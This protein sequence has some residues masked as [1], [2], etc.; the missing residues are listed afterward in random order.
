M[1]RISF[2]TLGCNKNLVDSEVALGNLLVHGYNCIVPP[3]EAEWVF[4]N[5]C[6]FIRPSC[7]E[8]EAWIEKLIALKRKDPRKKIVVLGCYVERFREKAFSRYQEVDYWVGVHDVL[9]LPEI[10]SSKRKGVFM[11]S[12]PSIYTHQSP[13]LL[14][15]PPHYAYVKIAEGCPH[16]CSFC[17]IP[18]IRGP[19]R[20]RSIDSVVAEVR[21]LQERGV[22]EII[23]VAQDLTSYGLDLYRKRSLPDLLRAL[24]L[25]LQEGIWVRLLYLSPEGINDEL[26]EVV[27]S[28]PQIVK[29]LDI[30]LQHVEPFILQRMHRFSHFEEIRKRLEKLRERIPGVAIR[31][32]FIVGFPGEEEKHFQ[33]LLHFVEEFQFER[34]GAFKYSDEEG[35]ASFLLKPKVPEEV[36]EKRYSY[37]MEVQK[38]VMERF[39]QSLQGK[40]LEVLL[41]EGPLK[42][43]QG[44]FFIGR[45]QKDAPEVDC[46]VKV[47]LSRGKRGSLKRGR[48]CY[49]RVTRTSAYEVEGEAL[50]MQESSV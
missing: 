41:E 29:Y 27:A 34:M 28:I 45:T 16:R 24:A 4:L 23:L 21:S 26:I 22:Q 42:D 38:N 5:T 1:K 37:L 6:A 46:Q 31:T 8:A 44:T 2:I 39:H 32:T 18:S 40:V 20:S 19:L 47:Y 10:L 43:A 49:V 48:K 12:P 3:E 13:R 50:C 11:D 30:P 9:R 36:K 15:T 14:S 7:E 33:S 17:L 35:T 25:E